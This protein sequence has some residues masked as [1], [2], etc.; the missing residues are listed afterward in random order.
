MTNDEWLAL[1]AEAQRYVSRHCAILLSE[2]NEAAKNKIYHAVE[3]FVTEKGIQ[4]SEKET[5]VRVLYDEMA[6]FSVLTPLLKRNDV[7]EIDV[8]AWN[9]IM[10]QYSDGRREKLARGF[11][12][13]GAALDIIKRLLRESGTVIDA[14]EPLAEGSLS[15]D[16]RIAAIQNPILDED[17][18]VS[19]SIRLLHPTKRR[20]ED[21][22][23]NGTGSK[24]MMRFLEQ[25][26]E[27]KVSFVVAGSTDAGKTTLLGALLRE[28]PEATRIFAIESGTREFSLVREEQG[29]I[30]TNVVHTLSNVERSGNISQEKLVEAALRFNPDVIV[31]GE[32]RDVEAFA[33]VEAAGSGHMVVSTVHAASARGAITRIAMLSKKKYQMDFATA[34]QQAAVAFPIVVCVKKDRNYKRR[35]TG[36]YEVI[37]NEQGEVGYRCLY[38]CEGAAFVQKEPPSES[39]QKVL[40][41]D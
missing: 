34:Y 37:L 7:E 32:M 2:K 39:L 29:R 19:C 11:L 4:E 23:R 8:N 31:V 25:C 38:C 18:G 30:V 41:N 20:I 5:A 17:I 26:F 6:G 40:Q 12:S 24:E 27:A 9:D 33:T 13:K 28:L 1:L 15:G 21:L 36:I 14:T 35:V 16:K 3:A 10:V 22:I